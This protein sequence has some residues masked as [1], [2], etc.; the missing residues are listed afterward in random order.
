VKNKERRLYGTGF[1]E[2]LPQ[3]MRLFGLDSYFNLTQ[4]FD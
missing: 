3:K 2:L 4:K 1:D